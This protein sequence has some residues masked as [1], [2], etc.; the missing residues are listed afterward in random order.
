MFDDDDYQVDELPCP[1][2]GNSVTHS[3]DCLDCDEMGEVVECCDDI[4]VGSGHCIHGDGMVACW[5][6]DGTG[7]RRWCPKCGANYWHAKS[8]KGLV[9]E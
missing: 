8:V 3:D 1:A 6:C 9:Q 2:C 7:I 5:E 4:C